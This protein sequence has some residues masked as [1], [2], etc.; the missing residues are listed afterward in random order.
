MVELIGDA[1]MVGIASHRG[2]SGGGCGGCS[3]HLG[4]LGAVYTVRR[5]LS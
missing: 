1:D 5:V 4:E 3:K 2:G